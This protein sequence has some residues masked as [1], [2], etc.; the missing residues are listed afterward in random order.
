MAQE[1]DI[2]KILV[3]TEVD[4]KSLSM[5][6]AMRTENAEDW[7][8]A[9]AERDLARIR[10]TMRDFCANVYPFWT[11][12]DDFMSSVTLYMCNSM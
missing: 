8:L 4:H 5:R 2:D 3:V 7:A 6:G 11:R 12:M 9:D 10:S 1:K